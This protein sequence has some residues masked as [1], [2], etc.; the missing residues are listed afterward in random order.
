MVRRH[1]LWSTVPDY[2]AIETRYVY[3]YDGSNFILVMQDAGCYYPY[4]GVLLSTYIGAGYAWGYETY[5]RQTNTFVNGLTSLLFKGNLIADPPTYSWVTLHCFYPLTSWTSDGHD[6]EIF[7]NYP[8]IND[9]GPVNPNYV[10]GRT[11]ADSTWKIMDALTGAALATIDQTNYTI[12][13]NFVHTDV[14]G[15]YMFTATRLSDSYRGTLFVNLDGT[16]DRFISGLYDAWNGVSWPSVLFNSENWIYAATHDST[17]EAA[18]YAANQFS[19]VENDYIYSTNSIHYIPNQYN[20]YCPPSAAGVIYLVAQRNN[21]DFQVVQS[22]T[23]YYRLDISNSFPLTIVPSG[24]M[25]MG[26]IETCSGFTHYMSTSTDNKFV[27]DFRYT[28]Q[29]TGSG[30]KNNFFYSTSGNL[31]VL[32]ISVLSNIDYNSSKVYYNTSSGNINAIETSNFQLPAQY[33]F[34]VINNPASGVI[35]LQ[36]DAIAISGGFI[37]Y[38]NNLPASPINIIRLDD[39][40]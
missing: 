13:T 38:C 40:L 30:Y 18:A 37:P 12:R 5:G 21:N 35:F 39:R 10:I 23:S 7:N 25:G 9:T 6:T 14:Q 22:G 31:N 28:F 8:N 29:N 1:T 34:A 17:A 26:F 4:P 15:R 27:N 19:Y 33:M 2:L 24:M 11:V 3:V 32:D 16:I 36:Q 20:V